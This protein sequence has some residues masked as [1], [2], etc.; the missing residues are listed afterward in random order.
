MSADIV[1]PF[2][3]GAF[4]LTWTFL[5]VCPKAKLKNSDDKAPLLQTILNR[6]TVRQ[7]FI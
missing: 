2:G 1:S 3:F 6:K 5:M 7:M 4:L